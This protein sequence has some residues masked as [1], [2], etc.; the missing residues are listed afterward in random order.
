VA[1]GYVLSNDTGVVLEESPGTVVGPDVA[2]CVEES[3]YEEVESDWVDTPPVLTVEVVSPTDR[4]S[5]V[6]EK[7]AEYL[8][9]GVKVVWLADPESKTLTVYRA[10][11][12]HAVL[13][14]GDDLLGGD[15]LP[16]FTCKVA[17][18]FRLPGERIASLPSPPNS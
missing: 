6:N 4:M 18:F 13:K 3:K 2:Y 15:E 10:D 12:G 11:R 1:F 17:D 9:A 5:E 8:K 7:I 14:I 16:G